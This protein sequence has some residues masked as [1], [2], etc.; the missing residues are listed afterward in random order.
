MLDPKRSLLMRSVRRQNTEPEIQ[1]RRALHSLGL[2]FRLHGEHLPGTPDIVLTRH[3][4]VIFVHGCFW[5]RHKGCLRATFPRT[6]QSFW[7]EKF[8]R[9][10]ER[11]LE[12]KLELK[13]LGWRVLTVWECETKAIE[14]L[15]RRLARAFHV[16]A[17]V[18]DHR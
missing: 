16:S 5:H 18:R 15:R 7:W 12:N 11:D 9:N 3:G 10:I 6:R 14:N 8:E 4:T 1:V 2:R 13:S 17:N